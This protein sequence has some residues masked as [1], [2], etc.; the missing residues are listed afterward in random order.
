MGTRID[1]AFT[2][3]FTNAWIRRY[4]ASAVA[5]EPE[6]SALDQQV[7]D[8]D[9]G[10]NLV[11]G[12]Q[13]AVR[14][15]GELDEVR[16]ASA[17]GPLEAAATAFLD[18]VGGTSGPLFGLLFQEMAV[19]VEAAG[20]GLYVGA[21]AMGVGNGLSAIQRVGEAAVGDKTLV[22]ALVPACGALAACPSSA[23]P[24]EAL[25]HAAR[26]A[27]EGVANT[28]RLTARS[29]RASYVGDRAAGVPDPG[30]VG[31]G[32]LFS[33]AERTVTRLA[34]LLPDRQLGG[35]TVERSA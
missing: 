13:A 1:A 23:D 5:T 15:L 26:A 33:A 17:G 18:E 16:A 35:V 10:A 34:P 20:D 7:G 14:L 11:A 2:E 25:S 8:G 22:D 9:F 6:L 21:L 24:I 27:W 31:I 3:G 32:L 30:A 19:A 28:A 12:L 29:G 4:A